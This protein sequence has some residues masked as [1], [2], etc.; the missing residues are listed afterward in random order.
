MD[1][2]SFAVPSAAWDVAFT[3]KNQSVLAVTLSK[4][5]GEQQNNQN[6]LHIEIAQSENVKSVLAKK[7]R[8]S[9]F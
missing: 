5:Y 7:Q 8:R 9:S 4:F 6:I 2:L 1:T 3:A